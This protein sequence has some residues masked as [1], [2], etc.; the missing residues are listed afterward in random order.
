LLTRNAEGDVQEAR[1]AIDRL[2]AVPADP[3]LVLRDLPLLRL[4]ALIA[5]AEGDENGYREFADR[6]RELASDL[7]FEA[8]M[9]IAEAMT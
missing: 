3:R 9:A 8:H 1:A 4:R 7:G 2:A 5:R 6:Y